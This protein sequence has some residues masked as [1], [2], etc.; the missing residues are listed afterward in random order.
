VDAFVSVPKMKCH[1]TAGITSAMKNLVG[2]GPLGKFLITP[3]DV[4]RGAFHFGPRGTEDVKHRLPRVILDLNR[5][6]PIQLS[7]V[8]GIVTTDGGEGP[9]VPG[10]HLQKPGVLIAGKN[11]VTTDAVATAVMGFDPTAEY[12][13]TPFVHGENH[14]NIA[15]KLGLGTNW[16]EEIE[17]RGATIAEVQQDFAPSTA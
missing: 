17:V 13:H 14:L 16:L 7:L 11:P 15:R 10:T 9:W 1:N 12:P 4:Y 6:R 5:A 2:I 3:G 8:D